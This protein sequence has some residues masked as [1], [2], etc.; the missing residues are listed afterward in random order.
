MSQSRVT[1]YMPESQ[2]I[3][4]DI[5]KNYGPLK[6]RELADKHGLSTRRVQRIANREG[7]MPLSKKLLAVKDELLKDYYEKR[8]T[9]KELMVKFG[10]GKSSCIK[11][12]RNCG[13]GGRTRDEY[14]NN[15]YTCDEDFFEVINTPEK[16]YWFGFIAA[17]G[18]LYNKKLQICLA[19]KDENHLLSFCNRINYNGPLYDDAGKARLT[20]ARKKMYFDLCNLGLQPNKTSK[21]NENLFDKIPDDFLA[22]AILGYF[23]GD[24]SFSLLKQAKNRALTMSILGNKRFLLKWKEIMEGLGLQVSE[25]KKDKRTN[26]TYYAAS[27]ISQSRAKILY[28]YFYDGRCPSADFLFRKKEKL[29]KVLN[30]V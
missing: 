24:G 19:K 21:I 18:N 17:D 7:A 14:D 1:A 2:E 29:L 6:A 22:A 4:D 10:I 12:L 16:A 15:K 28:E 30:N 25:I 3:I 9:I 26:Y 8:L 20:I 27:H 13:E 11:I 5:K 23:D